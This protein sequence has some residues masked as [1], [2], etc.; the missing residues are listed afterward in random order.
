MN[1]NRP[2]M[3]CLR[4]NP[5]LTTGRCANTRANVRDVITS[6]RLKLFEIINRAS[7]IADLLEFP[8]NSD[9]AKVEA[10]PNSLMAEVEL[11]SAKLDELDA[12]LRR[13]ATT[14]TGEA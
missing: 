12:L 5:G 13:I 3:D 2:T 11:Q 4:E 7:F 10:D 6:N 1:T 8:I 14:L 9:V